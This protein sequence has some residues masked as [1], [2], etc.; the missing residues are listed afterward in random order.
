MKARGKIIKG[1]GESLCFLSIGWVHEQLREKLRF[2]PYMGTLNVA[3]DDPGVQALLK[4]KSTERIVAQEEGFCDA[5]LVKGRINDRYECGVIIPL[6]EK[7]EEGMLEVVAPVHLKDALCLGDGDEV[8]L[9]L[10]I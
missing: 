5:V 3:A 7:Y 4:E 8:T 9:D 6:V 2:L 1:I 10:D